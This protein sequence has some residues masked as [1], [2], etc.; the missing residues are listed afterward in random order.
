MFAPTGFLAL[1]ARAAPTLDIAYPVGDHGCRDE[2]DVGTG[3]VAQ[4]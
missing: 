1:P 4:A 3:R 2:N